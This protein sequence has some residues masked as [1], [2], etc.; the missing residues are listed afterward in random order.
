VIDATTTV[1]GTRKRALVIDDD[2]PVRRVL[3]AVVTGLGFETDAAA[4]GS[5][6]LARFESQP[7]DVVLTDLLMPG[8]TGWEVLEAVRE[9]NPKMPV[10]I[11][12]GSAGHDNDR[13]VAQPGVA[14][15]HKP[16]RMDSLGSTLARVL[17][18]H[19]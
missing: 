12:T 15:V 13:R 14:L 18:D 1:P 3:H 6:G 7:Y 11:I 2:A 9:R 10:I 16:V 19:P 8:M 17:G 5:E 4:N